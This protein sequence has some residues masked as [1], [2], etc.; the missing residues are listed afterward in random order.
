MCVYPSINVCKEIEGRVWAPCYMHPLNIM[1]SVS[2]QSLHALGHRQAKMC[3][4]TGNAA[5]E[6]KV[7]MK[8]HNLPSHRDNILQHT[9]SRMF[10]MAFQ[11]A[12]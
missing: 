1:Q 9:Y 5:K 11:L 8:H 10:N 4:Y 2:L 12:F 3:A 7:R 6:G